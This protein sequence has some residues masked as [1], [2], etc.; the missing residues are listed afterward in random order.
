MLPLDPYRRAGIVRG[1]RIRLRHGLRR[2]SILYGR[3]QDQ[4]FAL[5][6]LMFLQVPSPARLLFPKQ[7][8]LDIDVVLVLDVF[9]E[10][11][12]GKRVEYR[13]ER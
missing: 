10:V 13:G 12:R 2:P 1:R 5:C 7:I 8:I 11:G 6:P 3:R 4:Y 9:L